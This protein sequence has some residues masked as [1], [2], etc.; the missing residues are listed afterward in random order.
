MAI[1]VYTFEDLKTSLKCLYK[2]I[3]WNFIQNIILTPEFTCCTFSPKEVICISTLQQFE[4]ETRGS[5]GLDNTHLSSV[6]A[7]T[8]I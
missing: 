3:S 8:I 5:L 4:T 1:H 7:M 2:F 6:L